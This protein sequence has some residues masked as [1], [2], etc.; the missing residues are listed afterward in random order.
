MVGSVVLTSV[1]LL[2]LEEACLVYTLPTA[3]TMGVC[4][5]GTKRRCP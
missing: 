4:V 1:G 2:S 3:L 5:C